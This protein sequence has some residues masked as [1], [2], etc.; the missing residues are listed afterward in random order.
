MDVGL[1][2]LLVGLVLVA[3]VLGGV[4]AS[5]VGVPALVAFLALLGWAGLR[6]AVPI[7]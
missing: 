1:V 5:H 2:L 7:V 4:G 3:S 6:G